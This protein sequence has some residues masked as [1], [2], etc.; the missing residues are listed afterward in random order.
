MSDGALLDARGLTRR[1]R[2][3]RDVL[4]PVDA[5][6]LTLHAG[7][8]VA[9][10]GPSGS[11]KTTLLNLL[12]GWERPDAG[13]IEWRGTGTDP[14]T[15]DWSQVATVPQ[16]PGLLDELS[17]REN[18]A[19][20]LLMGAGASWQAGTAGPRVRGLLEE[21][22]L[23]E[24][25]DRR[26]SA[27]S[28]GEQQRCSVARALVR[29]PALLLA[30]EPTAHQNARMIEAVLAALSHAVAG[31]T[32]CVVATHSSEVLGRAS[33]VVDLGAGRAA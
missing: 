7:E 22:G 27:T 1:Y 31:G 13:V 3:G 20:P 33:R 11:G 26:P 17:V 18:V 9:V 16:V 2:S 10:V 29:G 12:G 14:A 4:A 15:L 30:D 19:L 32:C 24:V 21:L 5:Y 28:L 25:A 23:T 8:L 6:D